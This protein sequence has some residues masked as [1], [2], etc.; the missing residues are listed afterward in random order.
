MPMQVFAKLVNKEQLTKNIEK[1]KR[2]VWKEKQPKKK[3]KLYQ[4]LQIYS[5]KLEELT[6]G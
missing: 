2:A 4:D 6:R 5:K 3:F 1:T